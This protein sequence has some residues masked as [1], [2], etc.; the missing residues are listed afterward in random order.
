MSPPAAPF[1]ETFD[2]I[3]LNA[4]AAPSR[5]AIEHAMS[6]CAPADGDGKPG[7]SL[8]DDAEGRFVIDR[9]FGVVSLKDA[10]IVGRELGEI[11]TV[12]LRV[13]EPSGLQY[14][15]NLPLRITGMVPQVVGHEDEAAE[16]LGPA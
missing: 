5:E 14:E 4:V 1:D 7:F 11:R 12:R 10:A 3:D 8:L 15:L 9:E 16:L 2:A 6:I 13:V